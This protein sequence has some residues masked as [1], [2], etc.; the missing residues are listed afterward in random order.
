[1]A[2]R[3]YASSTPNGISFKYILRLAFIALQ[4]IFALV[5]AGL[6]GH[7]LNEARKDNAGI[8]SR[9][10]RFTFTWITRSSF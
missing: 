2:W 4:F 9:W 6:Y 3:D 5:V 7:D 1:M 8:D 10:V